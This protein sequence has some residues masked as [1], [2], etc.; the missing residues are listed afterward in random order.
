VTRWKTCSARAARPAPLR[1]ER[2]HDILSAETTR[3]GVE[4]TIYHSADLDVIASG[5]DDS[6]VAGH[7]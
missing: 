1:R 7:P 2:G 3:G 5:P 6:V 4:R